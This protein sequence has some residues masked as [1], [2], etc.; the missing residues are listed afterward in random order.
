MVRLTPKSS[1]DGI[2]TRGQSRSR[3]TDCQDSSSLGKI[4]KSTS[5]NCFCYLGGQAV[6]WTVQ[7]RGIKFRRKEVV[8]SWRTGV[9]IVT[10][11]VARASTEQKNDI[12]AVELSVFGGTRMR[13]RALG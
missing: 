13:M 5:L 9:G 2:K 10:G 1:M 12:G 6:S 11:S 7:M 8:A 4:P 3:T